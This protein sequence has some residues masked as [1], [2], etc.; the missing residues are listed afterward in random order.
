VTGIQDHSVAIPE[1]D[2]QH[3][4]VFECFVFVKET[5]AEGGDWNHLH[6]A[7]VTLIQRF[8][9]CSAVEEALMRIHDYP[10]C[11]GHRQEHADL[12]QT[13]RAMEKAALSNGLTEKMI[14]SAFAKA[15]KHHLMQD[16]RFARFLPQLRTSRLINASGQP[17]AAAL[18]G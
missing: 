5:M 14:G 16:R 13:L 10:E 3:E 8:E 11:E 1:L 15:M 7:L 9:F 6:S 12:L 18:S 17:R 2:E 4:K